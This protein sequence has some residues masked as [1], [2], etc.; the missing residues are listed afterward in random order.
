M[1]SR[2]LIGLAGFTALALLPSYVDFKEAKD[3]RERL[4]MAVVYAAALG[5]IYYGVLRP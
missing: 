4:Q 1:N 5:L 3:N 2:V